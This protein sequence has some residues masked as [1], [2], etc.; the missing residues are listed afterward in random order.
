MTVSLLHGTMRSSGM[1]ELSPNSFQFISIV[2]VQA[3]NDAVGQELQKQLEAAGEHY[4]C[5]LQLGTSVV[6]WEKYLVNLK[7]VNLNVIF[8]FMD[9][10]SF[11]IMDYFCKKTRRAFLSKFG[12]KLMASGSHFQNWVVK[13]SFNQIAQEKKPHC[14]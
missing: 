14:Q 2:S 13:R 7:F 12:Q 6:L 10:H 11:K 8:H 5:L 1:V 4:S 3:E 9:L